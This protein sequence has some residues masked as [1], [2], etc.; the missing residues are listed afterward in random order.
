[1]RVGVSARVIDNH[2]GGNSRYAM[3]LLEHL[4]SVGVDYLPLRSRTNVP[5]GPPGLKY[6][7]SESLWPLRPPVLDLDV[8][9]YPADTGPIFDSRLPIVGTIHGVASLHM[10]GVRSTR[11][12]RAW[13]F[14]V[15]RLAHL[16]S[17]VITVSESSARDVASVFGVAPT[18][19]HAIPHGI[20][21]KQFHPDR[22][23]DGEI[24]ATYDLP[25]R[26][27]LY[28]G[29]LDPRKNVVRLCQAIDSLNRGEEEYPLVVAG[30]PAWGYEATLA[31]MSES[32][33]VTY[34]GGVPEEA[35]APLMRAATAFMFPS[36]YE[37]FGFPVLEAM[38]CGTPVICSNRGS[39]AEVAGDE[40]IIVD[41]EN[42]GDIAD[43]LAQ[44][45]N[46]A[47]ERHSRS[48]RGLGRAAKYSWEVSAAAHQDVFSL[49]ASSR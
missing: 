9:H 39:L 14:R 4:P 27:A 32:T 28:L 45:W 26:F 46:D 34:L 21:H 10:T 8:L 20:D 5:F 3:E 13:R 48:A 16:S 7:V 24:L 36:L 41:P 30:K 42:V 40:G 37:G 25:D 15:G 23:N 6:A 49:S 38:A 44:V 29:N 47:A 43:G 22:T 18:K 35:V 2:V 12:E 11:G 31:A 1:M 19:I 17:Q 33:H